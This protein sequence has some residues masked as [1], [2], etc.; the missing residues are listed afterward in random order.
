M[1]NLYLHL[2]FY[3]ESACIDEVSLM[4]GADFELIASDEAPPKLVFKD[5]SDRS[6]YNDRLRIKAKSGKVYFSHLIEVFG[7]REA[8]DADHICLDEL[9]SVVGKSLP[10]GFMKNKKFEIYWAI[11]S[12]KPY[13][14]SQDSTKRSGFG[15]IKEFFRP[16]LGQS[17]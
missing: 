7:G 3:K 5:A 4:L 10:S 11:R 14:R 17:K 6:V 9:D 1:A 15:G 8:S 2:K 13:A 16:L 12:E